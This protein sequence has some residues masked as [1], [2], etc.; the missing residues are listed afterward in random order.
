M[1]QPFSGLHPRVFETF[2]TELGKTASAGKG[3][4]ELLSAKATKSGM[5]PSMIPAIRQAANA[6]TQDRGRAA[7]IAKNVRSFLKSQAA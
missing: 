7:E 6:A 2:A 4:A 1:S 3:I 5:R